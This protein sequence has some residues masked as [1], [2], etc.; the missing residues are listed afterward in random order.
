MLRLVSL[1]HPVEQML[2]AIT[3]LEECG[4]CEFLGVE[5]DCWGKYLVNVRFKST[6]DLVAFSAVTLMIYAEAARVGTLK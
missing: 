6:N 1:D 5:R 4:N 3:T 2:Q